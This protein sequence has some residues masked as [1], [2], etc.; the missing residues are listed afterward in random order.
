MNHVAAQIYS[1][2]PTNN[3]YCGYTS[4]A[5]A[6]RQR[7]LRHKLFRQSG[8][9]QK[10]EKVTAARNFGQIRSYKES[11][12]RTGASHFPSGCL[13]STAWKVHH[14][15]APSEF[16]FQTFKVANDVD[17]TTS[18]IVS[19]LLPKDFTG[20]THQLKTVDVTTWDE[21]KAVFCKCYKLDGVVE[22][23]QK[24]YGACQC[25]GKLCTHF[26]LRKLELTEQ[27]NYPEAEADKCKLILATLP[28]KAKKHF[29]EQTFNS[30]SAV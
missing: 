3:F 29:S 1:D 6:D 25:T 19:K 26:S 15:M 12:H 22:T 27:C 2:V 24:M 7:G 11:R 21:L 18:L 10:E 16:W 9:A 5:Y 13:A 14:G 23:K 28:P 30:G 8:E 4:Q 20:I 17:E